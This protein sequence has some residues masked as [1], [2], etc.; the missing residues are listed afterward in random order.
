MTDER[1][2]RGLRSLVA[3]RPFEDFL[4]CANI[5]FPLP[6]LAEDWA[7]SRGVEVCG[8]AGARLGGGTTAARL[9]WLLGRICPV[10]QFLVI[11]L[12]L[13]ALVHQRLVVDPHR[14]RCHGGCLRPPPWPGK[15]LHVYFVD[16]YRGSDTR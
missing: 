15:P 10:G 12:A 7:T 2:Q 4:L 8:C 13:L 11:V 1:A 16:M 6:W 5:C 14:F 3:L 9:S